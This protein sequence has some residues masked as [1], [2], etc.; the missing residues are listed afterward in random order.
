L[1]QEKRAKWPRGVPVIAVNGLEVLTKSIGKGDKELTTFLNLCLWAS[2]AQL[3]HVAFSTTRSFSTLHLDSLRTWRTR[4]EMLEFKYASRAE[5]EDFLN[6]RGAEM[7]KDRG[8][9]ALDAAQVAEVAESVGGCMTDL[10]DILTAAM[11]GGCTRSAVNRLVTDSNDYLLDVMEGLL[12]EAARARVKGNGDDDKVWLKKYLRVW[13]LMELLAAAD[14]GGL[15]RAEVV[16][17]AFRMQPH[18][19]DDLVDLMVVRFEATESF[20]FRGFSLAGMG[21]VAAPQRE[22][23]VVPYAPRMSQAFL[24]FMQCPEHIEARETV[25]NQLLLYKCKAVWRS[26]NEKLLR[27]QGERRDLSLHQASLLSAQSSITEGAGVAAAILA[28]LN[29]CMRGLA[30][31]DDMILEQ[32]VGLTEVEEQLRTSGKAAREPTDPQ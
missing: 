5:V 15:R 26:R 23:Y 21:A 29:S 24:S 16:S 4:R 11:R 22:V 6:V 1:I 13:H 8:Q 20:F 3:V 31:L 14:E 18:E 25:K 19:L 12:T 9:P 27:L 2:D 30:K 10:T 7:L 28:Q 32:E 17:T